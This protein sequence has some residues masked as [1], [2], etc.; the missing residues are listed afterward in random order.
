[1]T[2]AVDLQLEKFKTRFE[3]YPDV[4]Q[5]DEGKKFYNVGV[6]DRLKSYNVNYFST[7]S[8][9]K[10]AIVERFNRLKNYDVEIFLQQGAY[11]W[12]DMLDELTNNYNNNKHSSIHMKPKDVNKTNKNIAVGYTV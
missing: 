8:D 7:K 12:V 11:N 6:R 9:K 4:A 3:K 10:A 1:M 2:K 5:F